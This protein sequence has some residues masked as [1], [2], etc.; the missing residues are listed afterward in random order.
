MNRQQQEVSRWSPRSLTRRQLVLIVFMILCALPLMMEDRFT[1][2][3]RTYAPWLV[4]RIGDE[5]AFTAVYMVF[6]VVCFGVLH[7]G[8]RILRVS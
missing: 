8:R 5:G 1:P 7:V 4:A 2:W 6:V 3:L